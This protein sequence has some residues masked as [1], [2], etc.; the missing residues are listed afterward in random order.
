MKR[1]LRKTGKRRDAYIWGKDCGRSVPLFEIPAQA[2]LFEA[3]MKIE[4]KKKKKKLTTPS[5]IVQ[6]CFSFT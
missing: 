4:N 5:I 1:F 3:E 2:T 6:R